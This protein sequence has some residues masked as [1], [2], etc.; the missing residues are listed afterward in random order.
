MRSPNSEEI[1]MADSSAIAADATQRQASHDDTHLMDHPDSTEVIPI[2]DIG[3]ALAGD[4]AG[5][6][7]VA[8]QL[9]HI[10]ET[11]GFFYLKG[12][13]VPQDLV[14]RVFAQSRKFHSL[15]ADVKAKVPHKFTDSFQ[16]G[17]V[18]PA[19]PRLKSAQV[20]I[21]ENAKPNLLAKFLVTRELP[22]SDPRHKPINVWPENLEGFRET[23]TEYH[24]AIEV[25]ARRFLPIWAASLA[26]SADY[27]DKFFKDPHLTLSLLNYPPQ[28]VVGNRQYG[29]APHTD[30]SFMTFLAQSNVPGLA[31][32]M[33]S[34][35]WRIVENIPGTFLVNTGNV[36]T[37]WTNDQ[38]LSTKHRVINTAEVDRYSIPM[39]FGPSGDALIE[40][41]PTC[42]S[43]AHPA[44][45]KPITYRDLREWYYGLRD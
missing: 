3:P 38:Y 6:K 35:H 13:Q 5:L 1:T 7:S 29:I 37:R 39:F 10:T 44:K 41:I 27:F 11:I 32:R 30:N 22:V 23:V 15:P 16:S 9:R 25:L 45:H 21:I 40:C 31:V 19:T 4:E 20:D 34:G 33:P 36:M 17:Y 43:A 28:K 24:N 42:Q 26:L 8:A 14:D 18:A 12:H 2:L